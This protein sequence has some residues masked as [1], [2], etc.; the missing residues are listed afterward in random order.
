MRI[1]WRNLELPNRV[2]VNQ[3]TYSGEFGEFTIEPFERGYGHTIG[4]SLRRVLLSSL[5]GTA[6]TSLKIEDVAHEFTA[7]PGVM[8]DVTDIVLNLKS[9]L[10]RLDTDETVR[11]ALHRTGAGDVLAGE[12]VGPPTAE[13]VNRDLKICTL[14]ED[15]P[16][17]LRVE[18]RRGR[19]YVTAEENEPEDREPGVIYLDSIF[20]P[21]RRVSFKVENTRVGKLT[22]YDRLILNVW[23]DGTVTPDLA[24]V[25]GSKILRKHLNCLVHY[26]GPGMEVQGELSAEEEERGAG[27][28]AE[29]M[30]KLSLPVSELN[31]SVRASNC[32][33]SE[34]IR[35][36]GELVA[37]DENQLLGVRNFGKT[38]LKEIQDKL[39]ALGLHLGMDVSEYLARIEV[40][41]V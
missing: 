29:L 1:R 14:S 2:T 11:L 20:S 27:I 12:L 18:V 21:V 23:T 6:V 22:N 24:L 10:V 37:R 41:S 36:V 4:N 25:E 13:V 39:E 15:A 7:I 30:R 33:E 40:P 16:L 19:G 9:L 8:E 5:E 35:T 26:P 31:L 3:D 34:S 32:V 28:D 38:T 17:K